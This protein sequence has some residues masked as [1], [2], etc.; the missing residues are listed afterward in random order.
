[1]IVSYFIILA[2]LL[3]NHIPQKMPP[4][5]HQTATAMHQILIPGAT[6]P[7][8]FEYAICRK[9]QYFAKFGLKDSRED[10]L[11]RNLSDQLN[12]L[13]GFATVPQQ[14]Y[15]RKIIDIVIWNANRTPQWSLES[16]HF[17][18]HQNP[19]DIKDWIVYALKGPTGPIVDVKKLCDRG[20]TNFQILQLQTEVV[21][22]L[23]NTLTTAETIELWDHFGMLNWWFPNGYND[24]M[25][26]RSFIPN[27]NWIIHQLRI[28]LWVCASAHTLDLNCYYGYGVDT[29]S[30]NLSTSTAAQVKVKIHYI[31]SEPKCNVGN[32][33]ETTIRENVIRCHSQMDDK[34]LKKF[35]DLKPE[36]VQVS[37]I[38]K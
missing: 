16:K 27:R 22:I 25:N 23:P 31:V 17:S 24:H 7:N 11:T 9:R 38:F 6:H 2:K 4:T 19:R 30:F 13:F 35:E 18:P 28:P 10:Y 14:G 37:Q 34:K 26:I 21:E 36:P 1:M 32:T 5:K 33:S 29:V 20:I 12:A 8:P 3:I 15:L